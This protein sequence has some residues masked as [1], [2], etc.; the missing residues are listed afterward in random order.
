MF[1]DENKILQAVRQGKLGIDGLMEALAYT[2]PDE[3]AWE[4]LLDYLQAQ[5]I[6]FEPADTDRVTQVPSGEQRAAAEYLQMLRMQALP[7]E[8]VR[9]QMMQA[10]LNRELPADTLAGAYISEIV[11]VI[12]RWHPV[13]DAFAQDLAGEGSMGLMMAI[14]RLEED[15]SEADF[16][17]SVRWWIEAFIMKAVYEQ[18][19]D[20]RLSGHLAERMNKVKEAKDRLGSD[21]STADLMAATGLDRAELDTVL[22]ELNKKKVSDEV[23][24][25][26]ADRAAEI[27]MAVDSAQLQSEVAS[28]DPDE[29][30]ILQS[31]YGM[32]GAKPQSAEEIGD[33]MGLTEFEVRR[34]EKKAL[35]HLR[36]IREV[37]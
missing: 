12:D 1:F 14:A 27:D 29:Q 16:G 37:D 35:A 11:P 7:E 24:L 19:L 20:R 5:E 23:D 22:N 4:E 15:M 17:D 28:L 9:L 33:R 3:A 10:Y 25:A 30:Y 8:A 32:N 2:E 13:M 31:L 21:A 36:K 18:H 6:S 26:D 34:L